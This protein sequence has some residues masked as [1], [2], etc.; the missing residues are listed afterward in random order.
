MILNLFTKQQ[1]LIY[2]PEM[3]KNQFA[4]YEEHVT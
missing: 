3:I 2:D 4:A 1:N